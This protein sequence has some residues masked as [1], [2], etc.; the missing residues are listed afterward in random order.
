MHRPGKSAFTLT[1]LL[2]AIAVICILVGLL[3]PF[4][5]SAWAVARGMQ[6][7]TNLGNIYK[8]EQAFQSQQLLGG[9][10]TDGS[11]CFAT[12][13]G[14]Q[15]LLQ[16]FLESTSCFMCPENSAYWAGTAGTGSSSG[17]GNST[18]ANR[19]PT[20]KPGTIELRVYQRQETAG[21]NNVDAGYPVGA[22][23]WSISIPNDAGWV[24][25]QQMGDHLRVKVDDC[26]SAGVYAW[27]DYWFDLYMDGGMPTKMVKVATGDSGSHQRYRP[28][29]WVGST[30]I[31]NDWTA[32]ASGDIVNMPAEARAWA[33]YGLSRG[34]YARTNNMEICRTDSKLIM[35]LDY[36]F[37]VADYSSID[38]NDDW[39]RVFITDIK[40]WRQTY[41]TSDTDLDWYA[42]Q[43][44]R[45]GGRANVLFCDGRVDEL[46]P[47]DLQQTNPLWWYSGI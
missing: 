41:K 29:L 3:L 21:P 47:E 32:E 25:T 40:W 6:C 10:P 23:R 9:T 20:N 34:I 46:P 42:Y 30:K 19:P 16:P 2:I 7:K 5:G 38:V 43:A 11:T 12:G 8:A 44:L 26:P 35:V 33:D 18:G 14:W 13:S 4:G 31:S 27:D 15:A 45:H 24:I 36:P 17:S 1:E 28:E 39:K 37:P 22:Y